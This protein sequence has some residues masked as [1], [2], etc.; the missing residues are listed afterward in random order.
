MQR[1]HL[2]GVE[3]VI[4]LT[5]GTREYDAEG[6][7]HVQ[8]AYYEPSSDNN[9]WVVLQET[10]LS[11]I[12]NREPGFRAG[13]QNQQPWRYWFSTADDSNSAK[14][15]IGLDPIPDTTT[16]TG[17]PRV[18][19]YGTKYAALSGSDSIPSALLSEDVV[20]IGMMWRWVM[21]TDAQKADYWKKNFEKQID[22]NVIHTEH[23][24]EGVNFSF[25]S[26][27]AGNMGRVV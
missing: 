21:R 5:A 4:S 9:R 26:P 16:A 15:V 14:S 24:A 17:Y 18:R 10:S 12:A 3:V 7:F 1:T 23:K 8:E 25:I 20:L 11:S 6:L 27:F 13:Q 2:R 22:L 19:L